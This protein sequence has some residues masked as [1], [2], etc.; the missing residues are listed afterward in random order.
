[1]EAPTIKSG[2]LTKQG[3][4]VKNWKRRWVSLAENGVL[5][6]S[7][8]KGDSREKGTLAIG[9]AAVTPVPEERFRRAD[10]DGPVVPEDCKALRRRH[11]SRQ[12]HRCDPQ[13]EQRQQ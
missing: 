11:D 10:I 4:R 7:E 8:D 5:S 3:H 12:R 1:M 13:Q 6:Y 9:A 2:Y